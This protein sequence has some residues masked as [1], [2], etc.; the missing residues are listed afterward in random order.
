MSPMFALVLA[1]A[2]GVFYV[3]LSEEVV[4]AHTAKHLVPRRWPLWLGRDEAP[5]RRNVGWLAVEIPAA[6]FF[7]GMSQVV[8]ASLAVD[9][10]QE[11][12]TRLFA[13]AELAFAAI[14]TGWLFA[15]LAG[16]R[17]NVA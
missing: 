2:V 7:V 11:I 5:S 9:E 14:W 8:M 3:G 17:R 16:Y 10:S 1:A 4:S 6:V 15:I 12:L 13:I